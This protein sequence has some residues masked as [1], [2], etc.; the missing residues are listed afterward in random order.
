LAAINKDC[1]KFN[2]IFVQLKAIPR[3]G[4]NSEKF[5][6]EALKLYKEEVKEDF[7]FL[8][9]WVYLKEKPKWVNTSGVC[10]P[11]VAKKSSLKI[12]SLWLRIQ[13][14]SRR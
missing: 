14:V 6:E 7:K 12:F 11:A 5:E 9:C 10:C 13:A 4:W 8:S 3:S 2:G 1:T